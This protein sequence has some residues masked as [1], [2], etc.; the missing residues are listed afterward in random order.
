MSASGHSVAAAMHIYRRKAPFLPI[1]G[2]IMIAVEDRFRAV[3][4][5]PAKAAIGA[6]R[7]WMIAKQGPAKVAIF[8]SIPDCTDGLLSG[9][10]QRETVITAHR[11]WG[12]AAWDGSPVCGEIHK[13]PW[14]MTQ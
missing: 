1:A 5:A 4:K 7:V 3:S 11:E 10:P 9:I 12:D 14:T 13:R 2:P 8:F 6:T